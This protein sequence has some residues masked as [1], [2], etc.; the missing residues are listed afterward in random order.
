MTRDIDPERYDPFGRRSTGTP[1]PERRQRRKPRN[2]PT[3]DVPV[4]P[5]FDRRHWIL[6]NRATGG[7]AIAN[8]S[9]RPLLRADERFSVAAGLTLLGGLAGGPA[10]LALRSVLGMRPRRTLLVTAAADSNRVHFAMAEGKVRGL[11][12]VAGPA[13]RGFGRL[14][15]RSARFIGPAFWNVQDVLGRTLA[16][17]G[18][19]K[20]SLLSF[21]LSETHRPLQWTDAYD[22]RTLAK[23]D[24]RSG[25]AN[26][27]DL[28]LSSSASPHLRLMLLAAATTELLWRR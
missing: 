16:V 23:L 3:T 14:Q 9:K 25:L 21:R 18:R 12:G 27:F 15:L 22:G 7:V 10:F 1:P 28:K 8:G 20:T 19:Q 26:S 6:R 17:G 5:V 13:D 4:D 24:L 2:R 11:L